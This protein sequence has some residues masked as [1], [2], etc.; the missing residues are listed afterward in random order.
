MGSACQAG[1]RSLETELWFRNYKPMNILRRSYVSFLRKPNVVGVCTCMVFRDSCGSEIIDLQ[2]EYIIPWY[3]SRRRFYVHMKLLQASAHTCWY[4]YRKMRNS[5]V[6]TLTL[7]GRTHSFPTKK[8][9]LDQLSVP[10]RL[11][12]L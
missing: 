11:V 10:L 6:V 1:A 8:S 7:S 9:S 4:G 3:T 12:L 5:G 2:Y